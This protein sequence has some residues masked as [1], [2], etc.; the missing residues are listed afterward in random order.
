MSAGDVVRVTL[1]PKD[2][3]EVAIGAR[4]IIIDLIADIESR[5]AT[6]PFPA[7]G[8]I[9]DFK[10]PETLIPFTLMGDGR[11]DRGVYAPTGVGADKLMI[12]GARIS[13]GE[14]VALIGADKTS[15]YGISAVTRLLDGQG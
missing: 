13:V 14:E 10:L 4:Q 1:V 15:V 2:V 12:R 6:G 9:G 3:E 5:Q 11:I 8:R 7:F